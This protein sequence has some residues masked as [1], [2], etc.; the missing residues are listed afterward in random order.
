MWL[1]D[2]ISWT[3][4][5]SSYHEAVKDRHVWMSCIR[6]ACLPFHG[7]VKQGQNLEAGRGRSY[8]ADTNFWRSRPRPKPKIIIK[9]YQIMINNWTTY[10]L[11]L[12]PEKLTKFPNFTRFLPQK[13]PDYVRQQDQGQAKA[14]CLRPRPRLRAEAKSL[15]PRPKFWPWD[16]FGLQ[17]LTSLPSEAEKDSW[18]WWLW[19]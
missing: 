15:R 19:L 16:H 1:D 4:L 17:D 11:R 5:A 8:E 3:N 10:D 2:I 12:L 18:W 14:K 13:M 7:D 9:K 6:A